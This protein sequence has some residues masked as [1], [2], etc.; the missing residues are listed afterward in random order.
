MKRNNLNEFVKGWFI[1]NFEPSILKTDTF[2]V[3]VK[4]YKQGD[5]ENFHYHKL[6]IEYTVIIEGKVIMNNIEFKKDDIIEIKPGENT[7]FICLTDVTTVVIKTPS[8]K[9]DKY[10]T[11]IT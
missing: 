8:I 7:N 6:A 3:S 11:N 2:E 1:G 9:G 10:E 5:V 4:R